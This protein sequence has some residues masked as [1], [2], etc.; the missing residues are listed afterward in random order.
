MKKNVAVLMLA[1]SCL[2][3]IGKIA[4]A[5]ERTFTL[6][7]DFDQGTLVNLNHDPNHDQLQL[8]NAVKPFPFINIPASSRG[9]VVRVNT[10][11]G[12][13]V[14]EYRTAPEGRGLS[15]SRTTVDKYGNVWTG[16]RGEAGDNKG[17]AVKIGIVV[18]GTRCDEN[19]V[20][21]ADGDYVKLEPNK[22]TYNTC[23]D[24][25][26]DGLI[27][28]SKGLG[29]FLP[30]LD[31][32]DGQGGAGGGDAR[33]EDAEDECILIY[34]RL[35]DAH[36]TRHIS[37][38]RENNVWAAGYYDSP[39]TF[40]KMDGETG[41]IIESFD[42]RKFGCGG[43]GGTIINNEFD[44]ILGH[45]YL[46]SASLIESKLL[47]YDPSS[48][49]GICIPVT[50]SYGIGISYD[51]FIWNNMHLAPGTVTK[52]HPNGFQE[53]G[54]PVATGGDA[55][56]GLAVTPKDNNVWSAN[57]GSGTVSRLDANGN[58]IAIIPVGMTPTGV[59]VDKVGKVWV[60]NLGSD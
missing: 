57:S 39:R 42:A 8:N 11:T 43:Y 15:P 40:H 45:D 51:G 18:G 28:T 17:S 34:Q 32:G 37:V 46:W 49:T 36:N 35:P 47:R 50:A 6:D 21:N 56:R 26:G 44:Q 25:N 4:L 58:I 59:A 53:A 1:A 38:D 9:T 12:E 3:G 14:G 20:P 41:A 33:V 52:V 7:A 23:V 22:L 54:F 31:K 2:P 60:T 5:E 16:N 55:G 10:E 27:R 13:I 24:R 29:D 48:K 30:W 19:G